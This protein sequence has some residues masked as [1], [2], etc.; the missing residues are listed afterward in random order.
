MELNYFKIGHVAICSIYG[1]NNDTLTNTEVCFTLPF[2]N[3]SISSIYIKDQ[4]ATSYRFTI[5]SNSN[6]VWYNGPTISA[7]EFIPRVTFIVL[8]K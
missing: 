6:E 2:K 8:S 4:I 3:D 5:P 7:N 1:S